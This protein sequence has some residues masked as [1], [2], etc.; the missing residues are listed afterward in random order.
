MEVMRDRADNCVI[1]CSIEIRPP[2]GVHTG[3]S[4]LSRRF[5]TLT[6]RNFNHARPELRR[7]PSV[8]VETG[9]VEHP[10]R[11]NPDKRPHGHH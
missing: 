9:G 6:T 4:S 7:D 10:V 8:G 1:I 11:L 2:M 3:D 5:K